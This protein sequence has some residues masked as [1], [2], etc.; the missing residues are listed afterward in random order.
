MKDLNSIRLKQKITKIWGT[1]EKQQPKMEK[2][3]EGVRD[4]ITQFE[5]NQYTS[6][7]D[8]NG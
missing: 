1:Q 3:Q 8:G 2:Q 6:R 4:H 7:Q 5:A